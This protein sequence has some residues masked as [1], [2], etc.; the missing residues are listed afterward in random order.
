MCTAL[1]NALHGYT[2]DGGEQ[3]GV[4][5]LPGRGVGEEDNSEASV[6]LHRRFD[7]GRKGPEA[8]R[9]TGSRICAWRLLVRLRILV[10]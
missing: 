9:G 4:P 7:Q 1:H 10:L 8:S 3:G 5:A 6:A 2:E